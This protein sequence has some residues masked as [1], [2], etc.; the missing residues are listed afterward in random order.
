MDHDCTNE[1]CVY[2]TVCGLVTGGAELVLWPLQ[3]F[4]AVCITFKMP[5]HY[6]IITH[7]EC[8]LLPL[9]IGMDSQSLCSNIV[10]SAHNFWPCNIV[11]ILQLAAGV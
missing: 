11:D 5:K 9:A 10:K 8:C 3:M 4:C 2:T 1:W 7:Y 6:G